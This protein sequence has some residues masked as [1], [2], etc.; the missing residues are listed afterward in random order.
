MELI[1]DFRT[2][3]C[4]PE[5]WKLD[6]REESLCDFQREHAHEILSVCGLKCPSLTFNGDKVHD[7]LLFWEFFTAAYVAHDNLCRNLRVKNLFTWD[8]MSEVI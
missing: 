1:E 6:A 2:L 5:K 3:F 4:G 8:R 7:K